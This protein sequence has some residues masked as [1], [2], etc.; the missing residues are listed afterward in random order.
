MSTTSFVPSSGSPPLNLTVS[1]TVADAPAGATYDLDGVWDGSAQLVQGI[2]SPY[3]VTNGR[4]TSG[5]PYI[6]GPF[7]LK[8]EVIIRNSG[9]TPLDGRSFTPRTFLGT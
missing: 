3:T 8:G 5:S 6:A 4:T 1:W 7:T 9:G 2:T